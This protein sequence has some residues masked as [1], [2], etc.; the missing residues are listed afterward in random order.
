MSSVGDKLNLEIEEL[1][2]KTNFLKGSLEEEI[3]MEQ[4]NHLLVLN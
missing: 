2:A 4:V 3:H 1:D